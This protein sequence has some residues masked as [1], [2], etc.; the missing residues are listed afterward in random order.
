MNII[1]TGAIR[2]INFRSRLLSAITIFLL[3]IVLNACDKAKLYD[4]NPATVQPFNLLNDGVVLRANLS[5]KHPIQYSTALT[6]YNKSF[7]LRS[8]IFLKIFPQKIDLYAQPDT[9]P[10][11]RPVVSADL[12]LETGKIYSMFIYEEKSAA[13]YT[14]NEDKFPDIGMNDSLTLIRFANFSE[15]QALSVNIKGQAPGSY[16]QL[17]PFKSVTEFAALKVGRSVAD[18]QFEIRDYASGD[19]LTTYTTTNIGTTNISLWMYIPNTLVFTGRPSGTGT[20][21]QKIVL[22]KHR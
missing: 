9:M 18:Y 15:G 4:A 1:N 10:H 6:L 11:D 8:N 13:A 5:G 14:V 20:N 19:L 17:L 12:Q 16:I 7:N 2:N 3:L 21:Q 22:M